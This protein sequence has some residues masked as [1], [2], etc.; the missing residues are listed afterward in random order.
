MKW[1]F[2]LEKKEEWNGL[3]ENE[4]NLKFGLVL[5]MNEECFFLF[6]EKENER[7]SIGFL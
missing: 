6:V 5:N 4:V 7:L 3:E 1:S 2:G